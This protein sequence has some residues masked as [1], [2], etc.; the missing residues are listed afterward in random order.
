MGRAVAEYNGTPSPHPLLSRTFLVRTLSALVLVPLAVLDVYLGGWI[1]F[2]MIVAVGLL[3]LGEW[4]DI[5]ER[6]KSGLL[7]ASAAA[8]LVLCAILVEQSRL[9]TAFLVALAGL[10]LV[11]VTARLLQRQVM[12]AMLGLFYVLAPCLSVLWIREFPGIGFAVCIWTFVIVWATDIGGYMVGAS[13]G[14]PKLMPQISPKKTWSGLAGGIFLAGALSVGIG[15]WFD[16]SLSVAELFGS[17]AVLA[18][19]AQSGDLVESA[20]KRHFGVKDSGYLIPGHGGILDRVDG[21]V[22]VLPIVAAAIW[23]M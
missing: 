14:G 9:T 1:F 7:L 22:P 23:F 12:W 6:K 10:V 21:L 16:F 15:L 8:S 2:A 19:I 18:V 13:V 17:G 3:M 5:T 20:V 4:H 11:G